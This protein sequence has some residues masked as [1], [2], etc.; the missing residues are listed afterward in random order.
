MQTMNT[1]IIGVS[2]IGPGTVRVLTENGFKTLEDI[3]GSSIAQ[4]AAVPGFGPARAGKVIKA[5]SDMLSTNASGASKAASEL[6][7]ANAGGTSKAAPASTRTRRTAQKPVRQPAKPADT[8]TKPEEAVSKGVKEKVQ[9][10]LKKAEMAVEKQAKKAEMA[11]EKQAKKAEKAAVE[12]AKKAKKAVE[13]IAKKA[14]KAAE[15]KAEKAKK[16]AAN[17]VK[18]AKKGKSKPK[19][20]KK[21]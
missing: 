11:V 15:E 16:A 18:K 10:K 3:A 8:D 5:A 9:E 17:L 14:K 2:G 7:S 12:L 19:K 6:P 13:K 4:L 1:A 21:K 20:G